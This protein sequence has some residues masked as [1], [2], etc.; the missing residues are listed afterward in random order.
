MTDKLRIFLLTRSLDIGGAQRQLVALAR[1]LHRRGHAVQVGLF[2]DGGA[3]ADELRDSG[4]EIVHFR[5][6]GR[7][8]LLTFIPRVVAELRRRRPD[9]LYGFLTGGNLI[10]SAVRRFIPETAIVWSVRASNMNLASYDWAYRFSYKVECSMS[11]SA[12]AIIANS[13]AGAEYAIRSGFPSQRIVV[14]ENGIDADRFRPRPEL[15][16]AHRRAFG[17]EDGD[18]AIGVLARLDP[19]KGHAVLLQAARILVEKVPA[20]RF[21]CIGDGPELARLKRMAAELGVGERVLFAGEQEPV[22]AFNALDLACSCSLWGEGFSNAIAEA[23]ACGLPCV[24]TNVGDSAVVVGDV[25]IVVPA[26]SP[27]A[28]AAGLETQ[29]ARLHDHDPQAPRR[30]VVEKF[31]IDA[32]VDKTLD[33]FGRARALRNARAADAN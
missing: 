5:K 23:M 18:I 6:R 15:R 2:Y 17:L 7:W 3:L 32:M 30:R 4:I 28:L 20:A 19:M 22:A 31:S 10:A 33:V 27:E 26:C 14:V 1:G 21:I 16:E 13:I 11:R 24:V 12:D 29:I 8:D 9:V 25:G